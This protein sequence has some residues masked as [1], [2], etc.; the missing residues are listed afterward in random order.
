MISMTYKQGEYKSY[1]VNCDVNNVTLSRIPN[2][3]NSIARIHSP[4]QASIPSHTN[5]YSVGPDVDGSGG[6][7]RVSGEGTGR[8]GSAPDRYSYLSPPGTDA[9]KSF[10]LSPRFTQVRFK[11]YSTAKKGVLAP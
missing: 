5:G 9:Q 8:G 7:G 2:D 11:Y 6:R 1:Y 3:Y 4:I 10:C